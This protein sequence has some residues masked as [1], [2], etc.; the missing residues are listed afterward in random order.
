MI[1]FTVMVVED[2]FLIR[3]SLNERLTEAGYRVVEAED[4]R[5]ARSR[6]G[7]AV[8]LV[9]LDLKLPDGDGRDLLRDFR[10]QR[11]GCCV[12]CMS[13]HGTPELGRELVR[14]G[15]RDFVSKPFDVDHMVRLVDDVARSSTE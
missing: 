6:F 5:E 12:V 13:A 14:E 8:D 11:P 15:A 1:P 4:V 2:E 10:A 9:L 7:D 3:W